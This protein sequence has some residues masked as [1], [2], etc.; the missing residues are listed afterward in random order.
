[1][2]NKTFIH[3]EVYNEL[4]EAVSFLSQLSPEAAIILVKEFNEQINNIRQYPMMFPEYDD[5]AIERFHYRKAVINRN[6]VILYTVNKNAI[7]VKHFIDC[8]KNNKWLLNF[9]YTLHEKISRQI[10]TNYHV[11]VTRIHVE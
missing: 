10:N 6:F 7:Y 9:E 11:E 1:M 3:P 5:D 2:A 8:R 4:L